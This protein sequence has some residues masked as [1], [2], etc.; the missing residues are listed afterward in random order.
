MEIYIEKLENLISSKKKEPNRFERDEFENAWLKL[1]EAEGFSLKAEKYLYTGLRFCSVKPFKDYMKKQGDMMECLK[2]LYTGKFYGD[3]C[4]STIQILFHMLALTLNELPERLDIIISL[5]QHIPYALRNKEGK[6]YGQADRVVKKYFLDELLPDTH[7]PEIC[8]LME[9]GLTKSAALNFA[10]RVIDIISSIDTTKCSTRCCN[11]IECIKKWL[12]PQNIESVSSNT[13]SDVQKINTEE[14]GSEIDSGVNNIFNSLPNAVA[15]EE[16]DRTQ[17]D[18]DVTDETN[19]DDSRRK[20]AA[21]MHEVDDLHKKLMDVHNTLA[22][23]VDEKNRLHSAVQEL[24]KKTIRLEEELA[25]SK[26]S[27]LSKSSVINDMELER[28]VSVHRIEELEKLIL[29]KDQEIEQRIELTEMLRRDRS[30]QSDESLKRIASKLKTYYID[31]VDA[32]NLDMS[33]DLG[34]NLRDQLSEVFRILI[35]AGIPLK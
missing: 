21:L 3:N 28:K 24:Q 9:N 4:A 20:V 1:A 26:N 30:K 17:N 10:K 31:Y 23:A 13:M 7:F 18:L 16:N 12:N 19:S 27:N 25:E 5:I 11:N 32:K 6:I 22:T 33:I 14:S 35:S 2:Q 34:E 29:E 15:P 8:V